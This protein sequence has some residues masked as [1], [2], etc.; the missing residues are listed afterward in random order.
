[1]LDELM[2]LIAA[3]KVTVDISW[4]T[5]SG[6]MGADRLRAAGFTNV[7]IVHEASGVTNA[8]DTKTT[9]QR[10]LEYGVDLI[11]FC[12]GDGSACDVTKVCGRKVPVIGVP[13]GVKMFSGVFGV[14]PNRCAE[15]VFGFLKGTL[16]LNEVDIL[17][18]DEERYRSG[19]WSVRLHRSALTPYEP[20]LTQSAKVLISGSDEPT[21][22]KEIATTLIEEIETDSE[23]VYLLGPGST[24][25]AVADLL[26]VGKT[27][28]GIDAVLGGQL[29][30]RDLNEHQILS[31]L[32]RH[33]HV[34]VV[35][36]PIGAQGFVLGRGNLQLSPEAI[37]RIGLANIIVIATPGKL[38]RT[39]VLRFDTGEVELDTALDDRRYWPVIIGYRLRRLVKVSA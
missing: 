38:A 19:E 6:E 3:S 36:S 13:A 20:T 29:I 5:C 8:E 31:L 10:F 27:L 12:G 9:V 18:L 23:T 39:P 17:D 14:N 21:S 28:L 33:P 4:L 24:V 32:D 2:R 16:S 25:K 7:E 30:A 26:G 22:K 1:M 37:R 34:R 15:L 35:L 11:V